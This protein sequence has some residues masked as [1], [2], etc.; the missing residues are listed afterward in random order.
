MSEDSFTD[1][2]IE[3]HNQRKQ[4]MQCKNSP[5]RGSGVEVPVFKKLPTS[6]VSYSSGLSLMGWIESGVHVTANFHNIC[7]DKWTFGQVALWQLTMDPCRDQHATSQVSVVL[8]FA[9][10]WLASG[11][12]FGWVI[13]KATGQT[14]GQFMP[15]NRSFTCPYVVFTMGEI[16]NKK[17][18]TIEPNETQ[19]F[20][21][22][23]LFSH[24]TCGNVHFLF[25][26]QILTSIGEGP[27]WLHT[28]GYYLV[29]NTG[30]LQIWQNE[31][32]WVFQ[33]F[34]TL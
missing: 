6:L 34:Q 27:M 16:C 30:C 7:S 20:T 33:V 28:G 19:L 15:V 8:I 5:L 26:H 10:L 23:L 14:T 4:H 12:G 25:K 21:V 11:L 31:I 2:H 1:H 24:H 9:Q 3:N 17:S 29:V 22:K 32:P 18:S 13:L